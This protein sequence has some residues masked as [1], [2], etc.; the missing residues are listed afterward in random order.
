LF[1]SELSEVDKIR[2][3]HPRLNGSE[4][5]K[6]QDGHLMIGGE[7]DD[8]CIQCTVTRDS[9]TGNSFR[10]NLTVGGFILKKEAFIFY[11]DSRICGVDNYLHNKKVK[12]KIVH[13]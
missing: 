1:F 13:V 2:A 10:A 3:I 11:R 9:D 12:L 8:C 5:I 4:V 6:E 7:F